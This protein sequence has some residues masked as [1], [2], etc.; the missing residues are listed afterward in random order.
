MEGGVTAPIA[1]I[2]FSSAASPLEPAWPSTHRA[3][4]PVAGKPL[5]VHLVEQLARDGIRHLR[6]AG[7]IQQHAARQR[8]GD[9]SEWGVAIR[10]SDLHDG[11]LRVQTLLE[12]GHCLY[13]CGDNLHIGNFSAAQPSAG[14]QVSDPSTHTELPAYWKLWPA[15]PA[16]YGIAAATR[17]AYIRDPMMTVRGY[18]ASNLHAISGRDGSLVLPG[19]AVK[20]GV[21]IDWDSHLASG[22][23]LGDGVTIGKHCRVDRGVRLDGRCTIGNGVVIGRDS[24]LRNV[25]VLPNT[26]IG[27]GVGL[28][29]AVVTPIGLFDLA[30]KFHPV[31]DRSVVGR[32]R[33][34][35][36][37]RTG[38]P[39]EKLSVLEMA[40][41]HGRDAL[42]LISRETIRFTSGR[43]ARLRTTLRLTERALNPQGRDCIDQ[44]DHK[45]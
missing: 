4:L 7:S 8:L 17:N 34:N 43:P 11:D 45:I 37:R 40:S 14:M 18:H 38:I 21:S 16:R 10:Y 6:I 20:P 13:L 5:I 15:G 36:E 19:R 41:R 26:Y 32:V 29:D 30:G 22:V 27:A 1:V 44:E 12:H 23:S 24:R 25:S 35:A 9:G 31:V 39:S 42:R 33:G 3:L 28:R 2:G